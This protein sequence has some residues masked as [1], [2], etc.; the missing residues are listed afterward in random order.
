MFT[1]ERATFERLFEKFFQ[2]ILKILPKLLDEWKIME[3]NGFK[4]R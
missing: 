2:K 1:N 4:L 3:Y